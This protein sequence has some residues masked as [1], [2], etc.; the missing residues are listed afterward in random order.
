AWREKEN[1]VVRRVADVLAGARPAPL[2]DWSA[3]PGMSLQLD[4]VPTK[5]EYLLDMSEN[6]REKLVAQGWPAPVVEMEFVIRNVGITNVTIEPEQKTSPA[7]CTEFILLGD[8]ALNF[9][10][11]WQVATGLGFLDPPPPPISLEPGQ[12]YRVPV[13]HLHT[14]HLCWGG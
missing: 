14:H 10:T 13:D 1:V 5:S 8:G 6:T 2:L 12:I 3:P 11:S 9:R 4:L 7:G